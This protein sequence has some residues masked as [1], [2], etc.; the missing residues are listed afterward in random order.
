MVF[1]QK[2]FVDATVVRLLPL[3]QT[4]NAIMLSLSIFK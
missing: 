4:R 1:D 2:L 3:H